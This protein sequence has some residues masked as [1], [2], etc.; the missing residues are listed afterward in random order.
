MIQ[1]KQLRVKTAKYICKNDN[2]KIN[3]SSSFDE[4]HY[5]TFDDNIDKQKFEEFWI[6]QFKNRNLKNEDGEYSYNAG[7][8]FMY[9]ANVFHEI[10]NT[11]NV[12]SEYIFIRIHNK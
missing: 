11:G 1:S 9:P 7:D 10:Y 2:L 4:R 12:E 6:E 8:V 3:I 5:G